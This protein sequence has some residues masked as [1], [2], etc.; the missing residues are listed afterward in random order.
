[1]DTVSITLTFT[2]P[3]SDREIGELE[4]YRFISVKSRGIKSLNNLIIKLS[5]PKFKGTTNAT[6]VHDSETVLACNNE[7]VR[8]I[9]SIRPTGNITMKLNRIDIPF[10]VYMK[11]NKSFD[12]YIGVFHTMGYIHTNKNINRK[13]IGISDFIRNQLETLTFTDTLNLKD[14]NYKIVIYNQYKRFKNTY[15]ENFNSLV[16]EFPD[17]NRRIR[18]EVSKKINRASFKLEEF[19][20]M[21]LYSE[22][23]NSFIEY[24]LNNL[25][26]EQKFIELR[27]ANINRWVDLLNG[28]SMGTGKSYL[29]FYMM[30]I[31]KGD[32]KDDIKQALEIY[33]G[34]KN[35]SYEGAVTKL[36]KCI[37][38]YEEHRSFMV[39]D[40]F[41]EYFRIKQDLL[42]YKISI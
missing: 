5:Y 22:Y 39:S 40:V 34:G 7:F 20:Y 42:K 13:V 6:L 21:D 41:N 1:M 2:Q 18:I 11:K 8:V 26:D 31:T 4:N 29:N 16:N 23:C 36:N 24:I 17:L 35:K 12:D 30:C 27:K 3:L 19:K 10:T 33:Y 37:S 28:Y 32:S 9:R 25:Y 38:F 14:Y 15:T